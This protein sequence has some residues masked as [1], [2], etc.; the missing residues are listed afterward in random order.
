MIA[1]LADVDKAIRLIQKQGEGAVLG[2]LDSGEA[3]LAHYY[4]FLE[5]LKQKRLVFDKTRRLYVWQGGYPRPETWPMGPVPEGGYEQVPPEAARLLAR[6]ERTY[7]EMLQH[8]NRAWQPAGQGELIRAIDL[9]FELE[10]SAK[11]LMRIPLPDGSGLT[12]GPRFCYVSS[13][14][15]SS[16]S[17]DH[18]PART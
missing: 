13:S 5:M 10:R 11:P 3:D 4:R 12:Y 2:P 14:L 7:T 1:T 17:S 15:L 18:E 8:L 6:F 16:A 9:M